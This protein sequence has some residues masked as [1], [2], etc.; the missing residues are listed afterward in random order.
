[1]DSSKGTWSSYNVDFSKFDNKVPHLES[2]TDSS[3]FKSRWLSNLNPFTPQAGNFWNKIITYVLVIGALVFLALLIS[4]YTW[5]SGVLSTSTLPS[6][7]VTVSPIPYVGT[8]NPAAYSESDRNQKKLSPTLQN[9]KP[10]ATTAEVWNVQ[11][12]NAF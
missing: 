5:S 9:V 11:P 3:L 10:V 8:S 4:G 2:S 1:M 6:T 7:M 12:A